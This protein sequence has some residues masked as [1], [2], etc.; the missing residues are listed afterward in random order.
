M[1]AFS[2]LMLVI[3]GTLA[4]AACTKGGS[5][6]AGRDG[7]DIAIGKADAP[8]VVVEY[9]SAACGHCAEFNNKM[10]ADIK[11]KYVDTGQV[12]W[13]IRETTVAE[14][15]V[16][17]AGFLTARCAGD[18][19]YF[20]VLDHYF[21]EWEKTGNPQGALLTAAK[22]VGGMDKDEVS[23]CLADEAAITAF[24]QRAERYNR[25]ISGTPS[26]FVNGVLMDNQTEA[27]LQGFDTAIAAA[28]ARRPTSVIVKGEASVEPAPAAPAPAS[29]A[30]A[31]PAAK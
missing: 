10:F 25:D 28:K 30:P 26:F 20:P 3:A 19:K 9:A 13:V 11:K 4:I 8:V 24:S 17:A 27:T 21:R 7:E 14:P 18:D 1:R 15:A 23:K 16:S 31:S 6:P 22:E 12:R 29:P 2:R 5:V